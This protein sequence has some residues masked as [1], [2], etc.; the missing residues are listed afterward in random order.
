MYLDRYPYKTE[1]THLGYEFYSEGK[2]GRIKT[3]VR[4]KLIDEV[5]EI[6]NL[7]FGDFMETT[8]NI[9]DLSVSNN[10]DREKVLA[11]VAATVL[12]FSE[13]NPDAA[14][15]ARG[16]TPARTRLYRMGISKYFD[17]INA[18]FHVEAYNNGWVPFQKNHEYEAFLI[19]RKR[20]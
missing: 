13:R 17:N 5:Y 16:S 3:V 6:Y 4:F 14:I 15:F 10:N 18:T 19:K 7:G 8:G 11:T 1:T 2:N 20:P 12:D 9:N